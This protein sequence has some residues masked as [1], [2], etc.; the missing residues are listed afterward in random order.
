[1]SKFTTFA[2]LGLAYVAAV[3]PSNWQIKI[4]DENVESFSYEEA[5]LVGITAFTSNINRAYE[6]ADIYRKSGTIVA[7][8]GIHASMNSTEAARYADIV[9][10]G[11]AE[12]VWPQVIKDVELNKY[13][14]EYIG[15]RIDL[16]S[17]QIKPRRDLLSSEYL[18]HS[19]QT[20]RGCPFDCHFCS[21]SKYLGKIYRQR[22]AE[23][24]L[25]ELENIPGRYI[26][27]LDDNLI[28]YSDES[29]NRA[30]V[31]FKGMI[32][33]NLKKKWWMQTTINASSDK[34]I[35]ELAARAGC[36]FAFI[37]F[38]T[39]ELATLK[40]M[41]KKVNINY[42]VKN[43][44]TAVDTFHKYGIAVLGAFIVGNDGEN[45]DY[46]N[47]LAHFLMRSN[48]DI[49]Q[50]TVLTP[51][52]GTRLMEQLKE[53]DRL[54]FSNFP[55]DWDKYRFSH[56]VHNPVAVTSETIYTGQN[57]LKNRL[58]SFPFYQYRMIKSFFSIKR[59]SNYYASLKF[60][61]ALKKGWKNSHYF[62]KYPKKFKSVKQ[63]H[64]IAS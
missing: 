51:L 23:D 63:P 12:G 26:A 24:V 48:I 13:R 40:T 18:W 50:I 19:V 61:Q 60:N 30:K 14:Q 42:G 11:E 41:K 56:L 6:I 57:F 36:M 59:P 52:P 43:Y 7:I 4:V 54:I 28:G 15:K 17:F 21:V 9:I 33:R 16:S 22:N 38:E 20:S 34:E 62:R 58:Y 55:V 31:L 47:R 27:F 29:K 64:N 49:V 5:D 46:Y 8:G 39:T 3:T 35:I 53:Q 1:M 2:P 10:R 37:G 45:S 44:K 32:Q 25:N